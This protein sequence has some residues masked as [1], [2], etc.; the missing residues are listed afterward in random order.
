MSTEADQVHPIASDD[1][2]LGLYSQVRERGHPDSIHSLNRVAST[3][4]PS[5]WAVEDGILDIVTREYFGVMAH[6]SFLAP[7]KKCRDFFIG[8]GCDPQF[9]S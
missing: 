8:H 2:F 9:A 5:S 3:D 6:P 4:D 7:V 1:E